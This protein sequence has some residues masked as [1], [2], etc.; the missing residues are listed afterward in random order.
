MAHSCADLLNRPLQVIRA[1]GTL[2]A[3][4][5]ESGDVGAPMQV[6]GLRE[7]WALPK[8]FWLDLSAQ[9][10]ALEIDEYDG[11]LVNLRAIV[12][13]QPRQWLGIGLGYDRFAVDLNVTK[14][15]FDGSL[16]WTYQGPM[17]FYSAGF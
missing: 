10:F 9:Y 15:R 6:I 13:W 17:I 1:S 8:D 5:T 4:I 7:L 11:S 12:L 3:V 14:D 2:T 16:D